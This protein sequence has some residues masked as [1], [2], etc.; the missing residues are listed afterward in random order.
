[1]AMRSKALRTYCLKVAYV[2][3]KSPSPRHP[4][5][6]PGNTVTPALSRSKSAR[7]KDDRRKDSM[8][9]DFRYVGSIS[10]D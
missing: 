1:M 8:S 2:N 10:G 3:I 5:A 4:K 7:S 6:V 9:G